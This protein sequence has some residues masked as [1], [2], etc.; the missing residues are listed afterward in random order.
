MVDKMATKGVNETFL[1]RNKIFEKVLPKNVSLIKL[2]LQKKGL[3][4]A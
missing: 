4:W 1:L 2:S 3:L